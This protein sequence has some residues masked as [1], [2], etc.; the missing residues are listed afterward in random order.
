MIKTTRRPHAGFTLIE[1]LT[2]IAIIGILAAIIIPTVGNVRRTAQRTVDA[3]SLR[4]IAKAAQIYA[5]DNNDRLPGTNIDDNLKSAASGGASIQKWAGLLARSAG[6]TQVDFYYSKNDTNYP[7][8]LPTSIIDKTAAGVVTLNE[9]FE[10]STTIL[11]IEVVGGLRLSDPSTTPIA[12]T[13]GLQTN[14][15]WSMTNGTYKDEG[16]YIA[17]VGGNVNFYKNLTESENQLV[18]AKTGAGNGRTSD[19]TL[20]IPY[21]TARAKIFATSE[22]NIG[23]P[24]GKDAGEQ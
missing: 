24:T 8:V 5:T 16:G 17:F 14:G 4:E 13:R 6:L 11:A 23:T 19:I 15:E 21:R 20:A 7:E 1:L 10:A 22:A 18:R 3:N 12:F 9:D 2:V